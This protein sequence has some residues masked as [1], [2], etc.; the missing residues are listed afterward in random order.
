LG[1]ERKL[2]D[3]KN[4]L[5]LYVFPEFN[6]PQDICGIIRWVRTMV[7][8]PPINNLYIMRSSKLFLGISTGILTIVSVAAVKAHHAAKSTVYVQYYTSILGFKVNQACATIST[9]CYTR[10]S[11][12]CTYFTGMGKH[13]YVFINKIDSVNC[14]NYAVRQEK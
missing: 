8:C 12:Q 3:T 9:A 2:A 11:A 14:S 4:D 7:L 1:V 10:G 13:Y 5:N 6:K